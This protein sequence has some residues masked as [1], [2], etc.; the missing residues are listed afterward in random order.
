MPEIAEYQRRRAEYAEGIEALL[1][2]QSAKLEEL[3][4]DVLDT[5]EAVAELYD[6]IIG[7]EGGEA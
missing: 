2:Q 7:N 3:Q 4:S 1:A 6:V 5:Q